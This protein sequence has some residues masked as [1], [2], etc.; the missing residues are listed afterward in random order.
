MMLSIFVAEGRLSVL[1]L[2]ESGR[3]RPTTIS[4]YCTCVVVESDLS[5]E[6]ILI[7][8]RAVGFHSKTL[9]RQCR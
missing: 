6:V 9:D 8:V 4:A 5:Q 2:G 1:V 3:K 7:T